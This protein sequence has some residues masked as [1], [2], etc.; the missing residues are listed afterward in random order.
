MKRRVLLV[1]DDVA[2]LVTLKAVLELNHFDVETANTASEAREKLESHQYEVVI[3][4]VRMESDAAGFEVLR[5]AR[6]QSYDPATAILTAYPPQDD[7]WKRELAE[8][9]LVKPIG[10][11]QLVQQLEV[12]IAQHGDT[13]RRQRGETAP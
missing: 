9:V 2:V 6:A 7:S 8:S 11:Q 5:A 12:L 3:T 4:D 1:D 13:R 10:T